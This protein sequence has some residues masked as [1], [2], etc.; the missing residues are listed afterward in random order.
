MR[1]RFTHTAG[2]LYFMLICVAVLQ[3]R[4]IQSMNVS[5]SSRADNGQSANREYTASFPEHMNLK[6]TLPSVWSGKSVD[7]DSITVGKPAIVSFISLSCLQC[8]QD[9]EK[10]GVLNDEFLGPNGVVLVF[11]VGRASRK[12][13]AAVLRRYEDI[14]QI[15]LYDSTDVLAT[16]NHMPGIPSTVLIDDH[17]R[18]RLAGSPVAS[19]QVFEMYRQ[20][21]VDSTG[22]TRKEVLRDLYN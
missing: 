12:Y 1:A 3:F 19:S 10:W 7:I 20:W 13:A 15:V 9:L 14:M 11:V 16:L 22:G 5:V 4:I 8:V 2:I 21:V 18:V 6:V 17:R